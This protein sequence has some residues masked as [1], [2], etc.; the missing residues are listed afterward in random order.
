MSATT[1]V[2]TAEILMAETIVSYAIQQHSSSKIPQWLLPQIHLHNLQIFKLANVLMG[3]L[4]MIRNS[5]TLATR[6]VQCVWINWMWIVTCVLQELTKCTRASV[7]L[8]AQKITS[9]TMIITFAALTWLYSTFQPSLS[10]L[11][12]AW[13]GSTGIG[14]LWIALN[15]LMPASLVSLKQITALPAPL[16]GTYLRLISVN[17]VRLFGK[18]TW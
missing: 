6:D 15:V 3:L 2:D 9:L 11:R 16:G 8:V 5:V 1:L 4:L 10:I 14:K 17:F 18:V 12:V 13:M 7:G